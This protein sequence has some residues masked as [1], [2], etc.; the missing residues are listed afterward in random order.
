MEDGI[1]HSCDLTGVE[2]LLAQGFVPI[3][4]GDCVKDLQNGYTILSGDLIV[5]V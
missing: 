2:E 1:L 5:E 4:H 3:L